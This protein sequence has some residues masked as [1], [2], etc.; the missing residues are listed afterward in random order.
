MILDEKIFIR[1]HHNKFKITFSKFGV[2]IISLF[3]HHFINIKNN[4]QYFKKNKNN[5]SL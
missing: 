3:D 1:I 2:Y 5:F 4:T